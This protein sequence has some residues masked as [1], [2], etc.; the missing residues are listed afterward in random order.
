MVIKNID[1]YPAVVTVVLVQ[2]FAA[3]FRYRVGIGKGV[4]FTVQADPFLDFIR[5][6]AEFVSTDVISEKVAQADVIV[7]KGKVDMGQKVH[8]LNLRI[9]NRNSV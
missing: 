8:G 4:D 9:R 3:L 2:A 6:V 7:T 5:E 1:D